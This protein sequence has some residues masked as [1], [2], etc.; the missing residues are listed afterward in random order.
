MAVGSCKVTDPKVESR[1]S[2][3][4]FR[5]RPS[6]KTN[7]GLG[8]HLTRETLID[9]VQLVPISLI[10]VTTMTRDDCQE[11]WRYVSVRQ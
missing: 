1:W 7:I 11:E 4:S 6:I 5:A 8:F 10:I 3:F 2:E 9:G